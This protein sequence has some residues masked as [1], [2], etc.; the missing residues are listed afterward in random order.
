MVYNYPYNVKGD[1]YMDTKEIKLDNGAIL[2]PV[3]PLL[4]DEQMQ[5]F[6][7][8][9][10]SPEYKNYAVSQM[11]EQIY[12]N[13]GLNKP[14]QQ[15]KN[16]MVEKQEQTNELIKFTNEQILELQNQLT[17]TTSQLTEANNKITEQNNQISHLK[18]QL[19]ET[20]IDKAKHKISDIIVGALGGVLTSV[21]IYFIAK[22]FGVSL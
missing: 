21:I 18:E 17:A 8:M 7:E 11:Q 3:E 13:L 16:Q 4:S 1:S 15:P 9:M 5:K 10:N 14:I 6:S 2:K 22:V 12:K 19:N 20:D